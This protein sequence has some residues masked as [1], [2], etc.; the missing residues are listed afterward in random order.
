MRHWSQLATRNSLAKPV[1]T[2][3][4]ILAIALGTGSVIW[5]T[6]CYESVRQAATQWAGGYIGRSQINIESTLGKLNPFPERAADALRKLDIVHEAVPSLTQR[7]AATVVS[8]DMLEADRERTTSWIAELPVF[9]LEGIDPK[10]EPLV[11]TH[12]LSAGR[13]LTA[14]D[15]F[16]AVLEAGVAESAHVGL[17]DVLLVWTYN[18]TQPYEFEIVGL[19]DRRRIARFQKPLAILPLQTLQEVTGKFKMVTAIDLLLNEDDAAGL[20]AANAAGAKPPPE[21]DPSPAQLRVA[22][23]RVRQIV[24]RYTPTSNIRDSGTRIAQIEQART[25][26]D[27]ILA[28]L[29]SVALL[30]SLFIILSTLSMGMIERIGQLG[31]L[32]CIGMT[33]SQL[34]LLVV[35]EVLPLGLLGIALGV[36]IGLGLTWLTVRLVPDWFG[37]WVVSVQGLGLA[38]GGGLG[39]T[40]LAAALP[41]LAAASITP[42]E[43]SRPHARRSG[44]L[45]ILIAACVAAVLLGGQY[46]VLQN[47]VHRSVD[48]AY[49]AV[50]AV[51]LLYLGYAAFAPLAVWLASGPSVAGIAAMLGLRRQLLQEQ[52]GHAVWRS[53]GICSGMMVGLSLIVALTVFNSSF[54]AGWQFPKRFPAAYLWSFEQIAATNAAQIATIPGIG[55]FTVANAQNAIVYE[56]PL[57]SDQWVRSVTWFLGADPDTFFDLLQ[58]EFVQGEREAAIAKLR[59]GGHIIVADDFARTRNVKLDDMV[60]VWI[61]AT[62]QELRVAAIIDSPALDVAATYFQAESEM[63]VAAVGSVIGTNEDLRKLWKIDSFNMVLLNFALSPEPAPADWPPPPE[64]EAVRAMPAFVDDKRIPLEQRWRRYQE[65]QVLA[66]LR[67]RTNTHGFSG[68]VSELKDEIDNNLTRMTALLVAVPAVALVVAALGVANLMTANV[69]S[70]AKQI[71]ILRAVGATRGQVLRMVCGEALVLGVLGSALGL[72]LGLHLAINTRLMSS[73]MW[74]FDAPVSIPWPSV[75]LSVSLTILLCLVAGMLPA[76]HAARSNVIQAL[77]VA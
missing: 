34:A 68:T 45:S 36:P 71:A 13:M 35:Y 73:R 37:G 50:A 69:A 14:D 33:R 1:R 75:V 55:T 47:Q 11:R 74:G 2:I 24:Q 52:I 76:R 60:K 21:T 28:L 54:R 38:I 17:G 56:R 7:F 51:V 32:R 62:M 19:L 46:W 6:C 31:L 15:K 5:V 41:A 10:L 57:L 18:Q 43:A 66:E 42:L 8:K 49:W 26:E 9:D 3:G 63:R 67:R 40:L 22:R 59:Q 53:A 48:F 70:R 61:G 20:A 30:T 27:M 39:T 29:S 77:H 64:T 25:Q 23:E 4:A 44:K 16:A 72:A 58:L 65:D 12:K